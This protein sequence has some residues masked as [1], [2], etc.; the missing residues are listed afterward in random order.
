MQFSYFSSDNASKRS[1]F[2]RNNPLLRIP[3]V[4]RLLL[5]FFIPAIIAA[6]T[7]GGVGF[8]S[9]QL[10]TN[11]S[12]FYQTFY[13]NY[14]SLVSGENDLQQVATRVRL[15][16]ADWRN[17]AVPR[18]NVLTEQA[19]IEDLT[20][21]YDTTLRTYVQKDLLV[22]RQD[23]LTFFVQAGHRLQVNQQQSLAMD[24]LQKWQTYDTIQNTIIS[25]LHANKIDD[26]LN[27][28]RA[29][30]RSMATNAQSALHALLQFD[31]DIV[32]TVLS[33]ENMQR[34]QLLLLTLS[35]IIFSFLLI[36]ITGWLISMTL[37]PRLQNLRRVAQ[38]VKRG[39]F[40]VRAD[41]AGQDEITEVAT[42]INNMLDTTV[43]LLEE[44]RNQRDVLRSAAE[45]LYADM[46]LAAN[47]Q[48]PVT[49]SLNSDPAAMLTS[50]F[51]HTTGRFR[52]FVHHIQETVEQV[53]GV[54][55]HMNDRASIVIQTTQKQEE[56]QATIVFAQNMLV[57]A[58]HL[59]KITK[60][61]QNDI[62]SFQGEEVLRGR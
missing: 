34:E 32:N 28:Q 29:Q 31:G 15:Y 38:A 56:D 52:H 40:R 42:A 19:I 10:L 44:T 60:E 55:R 3:I 21:Q 37:S 12:N 14:A 18:Q 25:D 11:T 26:A 35:A 50:A 20:A 43:G 7:A 17:P 13:T 6:A 61:L 4:G 59:R 22:S 58:E 39:E 53:A 62:A 9:S 1:T 48:Q 45:R 23:Q 47:R 24:A 2:G 41:V 51:A 8:Q 16:I 30:G 46:Y 54:A 5:G 27:V 49:S 57:L 36:L 33:I